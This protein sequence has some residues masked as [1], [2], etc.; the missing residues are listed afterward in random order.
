MSQ[1]LKVSRSNQKLGA[2]IPSINLKPSRTCRPDA[3]CSRLCYGKHGRFVFPNVDATLENNTDL[4]QNDPYSF[5]IQAVAAAIT[6]RFFRWHSAGDIPDEQYLG[7]MCRVA[8]LCPDTRFLCFT[9]KYELVNDFIS[10]RGKLPANLNVVLSAWGNW[11]PDNPHNLPLAY[12][13]LKNVDCDIPADAME[14]SGFCGNCV[15]GKQNCWTLGA[16]EKVFFHQH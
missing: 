9:K 3:P 12:V 15:A 16:G 2:S 6:S 5:E 11:V 1:L 13:K 8:H 14:C 4:W 10:Q 7:M